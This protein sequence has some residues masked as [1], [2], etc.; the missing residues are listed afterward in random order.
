MSLGRLLAEGDVGGEGNLGLLIPWGVVVLEAGVGGFKGVWSD[1]VIT[2]G[3]GLMASGGVV[4]RGGSLGPVG[5]DDDL[6]GVATREEEF[7]EGV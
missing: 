4:E 6:V 3:G 2:L 5:V 1:G 7:E